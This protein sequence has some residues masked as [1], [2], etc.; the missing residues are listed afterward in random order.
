MIV[1]IPT[2]VIPVW[3][4]EKWKKENVED[5]MWQNYCTKNFRYRLNYAQLSADRCTPSADCSSCSG[6]NDYSI[7]LF[8][9][10]SE[11]DNQCQAWTDLGYK[12]CV[13]MNLEIDDER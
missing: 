2:E 11:G 4:I 6:G 13:G 1:P 7:M 12:V 9:S 3:Y 5:G 8:P 10:F